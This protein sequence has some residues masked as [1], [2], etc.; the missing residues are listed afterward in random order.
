MA[1]KSGTRHKLT[2]DHK[3]QVQQEIP[4]GFNEQ[5]HSFAKKTRKEMEHSRTFMRVGPTNSAP[6]KNL[7]HPTPK[8]NRLVPD[9][10]VSYRQELRDM[11]E[12]RLDRT[13]NGKVVPIDDKTRYYDSRVAVEQGLAHMTTPTDKK[14]QYYDNVNWYRKI[15][16]K[17]PKKGTNERGEDLGRVRLDDEFFEYMARKKDKAEKLQYDM[18]KL[19]M[20]DLSTPSLRAYWQKRFPELVERKMLYFRNKAHLMAKYNEINARGVDSMEDMKFIYMY[21]MRVFDIS[22]PEDVALYI[23]N[24]VDNR[25]WSTT[26]DIQT[27]IY[28]NSMMHENR[29]ENDSA[30]TEVQIAEKADTGTDFNWKNVTWGPTYNSAT[31]A[32]WFQAGPTPQ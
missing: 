3:D 22:T 14:D 4:P 6:D 27:G 26:M 21:N 28:E 7:F 17:M 15:Y 29:E 2:K 13:I 24:P 1:T 16:G 8:L 9:E 18:Y 31:P 11:P 12:R 25:M 30:M 32:G 10:A 23:Q 20:V 5:A 19:Q